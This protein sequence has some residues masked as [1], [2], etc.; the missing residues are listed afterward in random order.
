MKI[1]TILSSTPVIA[2]IGFW[3]FA[4]I[5]YGDVFY[6]AEQYSLFAFDQQIMEFILDQPGG[7]LYWFG[8]LL[9]LS[10]HEPWIGGF[11]MPVLLTGTVCLVRKSFALQGKWEWISLLPSILVLWYLI[12]KGQNLYYQQ[13]P[14][15]VFFMATRCFYTGSP[16]IDSFSLYCRETFASCFSFPK[17][18]SN[19]WRFVS[20]TLSLYLDRKRE[21]KDNRLH[22]TCISGTK[23]G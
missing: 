4:A 15:V 10:Y 12:Q 14:S 21:R 18:T 20:R 6:M 5:L 1:K 9:L 2:F 7:K 19:L 8:R 3:I 16:G 23:L 13:E 11:L 17:G 22:A